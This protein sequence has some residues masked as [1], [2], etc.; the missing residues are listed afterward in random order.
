MPY[1]A[2]IVGLALSALI[3]SEVY[4]FPSLDEID[5]VRSELGLETSRLKA[6]SETEG[7]QRSGER[8]LPVLRYDVINLS[9]GDSQDRVQEWLKIPGLD[10]V[11]HRS[12]MGIDGL[13][14][15]YKIRST[16]AIHANYR[17]G[18]VPLHPP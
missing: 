13:D 11:I 1:R 7:L 12:L 2:S 15:A 14:K 10:A 3:S 9:D 16:A 5:A 4:S 6:L 18:R 8:S 17:W